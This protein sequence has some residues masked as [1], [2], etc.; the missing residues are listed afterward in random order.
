MPTYV[1]NKLHIT[2]NWGKQYG[3]ENAEMLYDVKENRIVFPVLHEGA[4]VD[5]TGRSITKNRIPNGKGMELVG[6]HILQAWV[7]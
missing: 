6:T 7:G 3:I 1:V 2:K 4:I 5:A